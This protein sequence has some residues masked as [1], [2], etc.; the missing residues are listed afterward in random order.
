MIVV[1]IIVNC[2]AVVVTVWVSKTVT[3]DVGGIATIVRVTVIVTACGAF[4]T[5]I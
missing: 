5:K 4:K 1:G 3:I 2:V